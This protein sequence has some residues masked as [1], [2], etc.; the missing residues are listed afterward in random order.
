MA[1]ILTTE[2]L[3]LRSFDPTFYDS[4]VAMNK[5]EEV[6]KYFPAPLSKEESLQFIDIISNHYK[7]VGFSLYAVL[8][9]SNNTFLGFT[10][11]MTPSFD[12]F[13]TPCIE[14]SWRFKKEYWGNGYATEAATACLKYAKEQ[15]GLKEVFSFTSLHNKKS[16]AVMQKIGMQRQK[17]FEHPKLDKTHWLC[18]HVLYVIQL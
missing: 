16:E 14:I 3:V 6:M 10:G 8:L 11:F 13:F 5:E 4:F 12:A 15:L 17:N 18:A 7:D 2:R 1:L 9:A